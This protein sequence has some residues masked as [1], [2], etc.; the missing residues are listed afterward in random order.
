MLILIP[1][2]LLILNATFTSATLITFFSHNSHSTDMAKAF[3]ID[4]YIL[5]EKP[6]LNAIIQ[7]FNI[8]KPTSNRKNN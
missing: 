7:D 2:T 6:K 4:Q 3:L 8:G 5:F 1:H